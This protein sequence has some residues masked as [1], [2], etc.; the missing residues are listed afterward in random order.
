MMISY[1]DDGLMTKDLY[2]WNEP[3]LDT[4][5]VHDDWPT[6]FIGNLNLWLQEWQEWPKSTPETMKRKFTR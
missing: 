1:H 2:F 5:P 6:N 3:P 4:M